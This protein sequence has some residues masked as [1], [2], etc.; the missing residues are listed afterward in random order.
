MITSILHNLWQFAPL[1]AASI[2]LKAH[3][4]LISF[5]IFT[6]HYFWHLS[7]YYFFHSNFHL[8]HKSRYEMAIFFFLLRLLPLLYLLNDSFWQPHTS[9]WGTNADHRRSEQCYELINRFQWPKCGHNWK[10]VP[11]LDPAQQAILWSAAVN[12]AFFLNMEEG[13]IRPEPKSLSP[14]YQYRKCPVPRLTVCW[15]YSC[16]NMLSE[17]VI[18]LMWSG[19]KKFSPHCV[20]TDEQVRARALS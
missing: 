10:H 5:I 4:P 13:E 14:H 2:C 12:W 8:L 3:R 15:L 20:R 16:P 19:G 17:Y 1:A 9:S 11:C 7:F 18:L 6:A